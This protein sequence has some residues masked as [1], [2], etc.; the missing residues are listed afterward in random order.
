MS[1]SDYIDSLFDHG[2]LSNL[3]DEMYWD[4]G[5]CTSTFETV[6]QKSAARDGVTLTDVEEYDFDTGYA[7]Y[8]CTEKG[9]S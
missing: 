8:R 6:I 4:G 5:W 2:E 3:F 9:L 7:L 1:T